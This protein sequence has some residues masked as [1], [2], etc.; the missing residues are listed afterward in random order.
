MFRGFFLQ[1]LHFIVP[2]RERV[3]IFI[4]VNGELQAGIQSRQREWDLWGKLK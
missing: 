1:N 4:S 3:C 2:D